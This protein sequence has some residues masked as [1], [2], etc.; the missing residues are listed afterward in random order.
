MRP[1]ADQIDFISC[2]D[3]P[4]GALVVY[5]RTPHMDRHLHPWRSRC[6]V[7][8]VYECPYTPV[9]RFHVRC[10]RLVSLFSPKREFLSVHDI[11]VVGLE[12][13]IQSGVLGLPRSIQGR[14]EAGDC[15]GRGLGHSQGPVGSNLDGD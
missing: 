14:R 13:L 9:P 3:L 10:Q 4:R 5:A 2:L 11:L 6:R 12:K 8:E 15:K 1:L 7:S